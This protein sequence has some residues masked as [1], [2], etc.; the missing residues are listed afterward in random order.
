MAR[1]RLRARV[2][3]AGGVGPVARESN[4][5]CEQIDD[6]A[7]PDDDGLR[8]KRQAER[9]FFVAQLT[10]LDQLAQQAKQQDQPI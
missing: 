8:I 7:A 6:P 4:A 5:Q 1:Q 2:T 3:D 10:Y 9:A